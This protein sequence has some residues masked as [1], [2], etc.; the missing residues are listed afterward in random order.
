MNGL[1]HLS[2]SFNADHGVVT[3]LGGALPNRI[4]LGRRRNA[5]LVRNL[6]LLPRQSDKLFD[7]D[8]RRAGRLENW[9]GDQNELIRGVNGRCGKNLIDVACVKNCF[10]E[11][12]QPE[13]KGSCIQKKQ[14]LDPRPERGVGPGAVFL[15]PLVGVLQAA[16]CS[17]SFFFAGRTHFLKSNSPSPNSIYCD[18]PEIPCHRSGLTVAWICKRTKPSWFKTEPTPG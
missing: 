10:A 6:L 11:N 14:C 13:P 9:Q 7:G 8:W 12:D 4:G 1:V 18:L 2:S 17:A 3:C 15:C 5:V 16:L